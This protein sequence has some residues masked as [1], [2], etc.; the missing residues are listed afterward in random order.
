LVNLTKIK[1]IAKKEKIIIVE[2]G[3][4]SFGSKNQLNNIV[5]SC[6]NSTCTTFSFHP[7]KNITTI[8]GGAITTNNFRI[9]KSLLSIRNH[10][11][12]R[13]SL[14]DPYILDNPS[15]N[16]RMGEIN[17][18]IGL[19]QIK[20]LNKFKIKRQNLTNYY[21]FK[22]RKFDKYFRIYNFKSN[23]IFW[24]LFVICLKK[25]LLKKKKDFMFYLKKKNI[26]TQIHYKPLSSHRILKKN[27][28][29]CFSKSSNIFYNSQLT[30][31]LHTKM[32][33]NDIDYVSNAIESYIKSHIR[34]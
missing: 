8:E 31:P 13:T 9:Y 19:Q 22:L 25:D 15:L 17:A 27:A 16:F 2:D 20:L 23:K 29:K 7:V 34:T 1:K 18:E 5:G 32:N 6:A 26:S 11:L 3:C 4:H 28:L 12:I 10:S 30:L 21:I 14:N 24:H 33:F